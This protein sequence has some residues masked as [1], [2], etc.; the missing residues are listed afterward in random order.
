M[1]F[2]SKLA[3]AAVLTLGSGALGAMPASAQKADK[4]A[5]EAPELKVS[6]PFRKA[7]SA[8]EAALK[9]KDLATAET[10]IAAAEA[11]SKNDDEHYYAAWLRLQLELERKN[12]PGQMKA[13]QILWTN[14]KTPADR[15][16]VYGAVYNFMAGSMAS[17]QKKHA[18]AIPFLLK[19][20]E[21]GST[22][23]D[24]PV[25][26][27]NSYS[28]TGNQP[29]AIAEVDN[30][31]KA[32]KAAGRKP[33]V[34]WYKFAIPRV[35][36]GGDRAQMAAWLT[37]FIQEYP[38]VQ[39]WRW[40]IQVFRQGTPA[41]GSEKVEKLDLYRLMRSTNA[42]ADRGDYADYAFQAQQSGLPWEAV[43]AI[44]EG[45]KN[46]KVPTTDADTVRTYTASQ[47]AVKGEGSLD[48]LAKQAAAA[49]TG[50]PASQTA[51]A[52]LASGNYA[53]ALEL[54]DL[55]LTKG[56]VNV[57]EVNLHRG[58]TL[59]ALGRKDE[60]RTAFQQV[61]TGPYS[62]LSLLWQ[63]SIDFPPLA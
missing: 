30:A 9:A 11:A 56:S 2:V 48:T 51:D 53:R 38:T 42:L 52:F 45:R 17:D 23:A 7:A 24:L 41:G 32:S 3:L 57:D 5:A 1:T 22:E 33:P 55:A 49:K 27:A 19:A 58:I 14:P 46:G 28:Q 15:A 18:E 39:N 54:Y 60:A 35:N 12:Q 61:K 31:I 59:T 16:K 63:A 47:A 26:L 20:R 50:A 10:Q 40:A 62:N 21:L 4:K 43:A 29:A 44:D 13:L 34:D 6:E 25:M 8:G 37:R 36:Q